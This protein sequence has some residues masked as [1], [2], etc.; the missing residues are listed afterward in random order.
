MTVDEMLCRW[1]EA[2]YGM[3]DVT[4]VEF[5][6]EE[7]WGG[8]DVTPG[9][10]DRVKVYVTDSEARWLKESEI[11]VLPALIR[12]IVEFSMGASK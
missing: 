7:G 2:K 1:A 4:L 11:E 5:E 9:D 6:H 12:E 3:T 8:T 10:P